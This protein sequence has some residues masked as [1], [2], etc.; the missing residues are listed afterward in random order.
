[1]SREALLEA[2]LRTSFDEL[3]QRA[4][5]L[6]MSGTPDGALV[7]W[8]QEAVAMA[9]NNSGA[10]ASMVAAIADENSALWPNVRRDPTWTQLTCSPWSVHWRGSATGLRLR[11]ARII[12]STLFQARSSRINEG[13]IC[14]RANANAPS[15]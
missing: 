3:T 2:L 8:L 10:I 5:G 9:H 1:M 12:Y 11:N 15:N 13:P 6:E 14:L 7:T 4:N